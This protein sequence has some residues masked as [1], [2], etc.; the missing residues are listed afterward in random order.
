MANDFKEAI[1]ALVEAKGVSEEA[2]IKAMES[3]LV[4]AYKKQ[5][6]KEGDNI[7][8]ATNVFAKMDRETGEFWVFSEKTVVSEVTDGLLEISEEE[9]RS[10]YPNC[11]VGDIVRLAPNEYD[12]GRIAAQSAR[13]VFIQEIKEIEKDILFED[14]KANLSHNIEG[15]AHR[16]NKGSISFLYGDME[17]ILP[18][19]EQI[20]SERFRKN[21]IV[22][23]NVIGIQNTG[24]HVNLLV[25]RKNNAL[26]RELFRDEVPEVADGTVEIKS[27]AREPGSRT[28]IAVYSSDPQID[29]IGACVGIAGSRINNIVNELKNEKVDIVRWSDNIAEFIDGALSPAHVIC[30]IADTEERTAEVIVPDSQLLLAIGKGGQNARLAAKLTGYKIDIK[31]ESESQAVMEEFLGE[32]EN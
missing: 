31:S 8:S 26:I 24:K 21:E 27:I 18:E 14:A 29:E 5:Y 6:G 2:V 28:K 16:F 3:A 15:I 17:C 11:S 19:K 25:S 10:I 12:F 22:K 32:K 4:T 1:A 23:L 9:A 20:P 30:V 7:L 13:N